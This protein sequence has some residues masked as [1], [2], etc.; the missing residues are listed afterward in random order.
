MHLKTLIQTKNR[1]VRLTPREEE[2]VAVVDAT[3]ESVASEEN[4]Q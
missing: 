4:A 2:E 1:T 3:T